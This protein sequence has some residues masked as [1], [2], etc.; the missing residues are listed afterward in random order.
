MKT[1]CMVKVAARPPYMVLP[2]GQ[3][4]LIAIKNVLED[5]KKHNN[6]RIWPNNE[7]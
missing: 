3:Q 2:N 6:S 5:Q 4:P 1:P 7:K